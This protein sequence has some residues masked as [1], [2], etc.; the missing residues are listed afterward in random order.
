MTS[1]EVAALGDDPPVTP[2]VDERPIAS[3]DGLQIT[4]VGESNLK[5]D[6]V[7]SSAGVIQF[8]YL[9]T[10]KVEGLTASELKAMLEKRLVEDGYFVNPQVLVTVA[11]HEQYVRVLGAVNKPG[12][13]TLKGD[14]KLDILDVISFAGGTSR[15]AKNEIEYT[16]NGVRRTISLESLKEAKPDERI[17]VSPGDIIEVKETIF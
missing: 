5:S 7:V 3:H 13:V 6:F 16:H 12:P 2:V 1:N 14:Q 10:V 8:P 17:W 9:D 15:Y 11:Y 4:I